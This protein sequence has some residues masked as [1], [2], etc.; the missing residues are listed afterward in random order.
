MSKQW[1]TPST[2]NHQ[3]LIVDMETG[4]NIAVAY[5]KE[6]A[7]LIAA[8]PDLLAAC[9]KLVEIA[10][11]QWGEDPEHWPKVMDRIENAI[12]KATGEQC[13]PSSLE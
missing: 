6:D 2:G 10:P 11:L 4:K 9:K 1:Y 12:T 5:D 13:K 7:P 8:A 3:G